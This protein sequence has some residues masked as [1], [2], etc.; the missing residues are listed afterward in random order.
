MYAI[1]QW[2]R[3]IGIGLLGV[4]AVATL[5]GSAYEMWARHRVAAEFPAPG[6]LV[7]IGGRRI[8]LDCRGSGAPIVV[9]ESGLED[10]KSVV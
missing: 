9:F 6:I 3:R 8:H 1:A 4:L 5:A 7:D 10:R 2:L